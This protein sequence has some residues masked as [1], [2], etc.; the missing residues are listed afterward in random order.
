MSQQNFVP[1]LPDNAP[2]T[3][4]QRAYLNGFL[5]GLFSRAPQPNLGAVAPESKPLTPLTILFGSQ[6]GNAEN[7]SKRIAK[8]AGKRGFA[9][10]VQ[11]L[12][13]YEIAQ[14]VSEQALLIVTSTYG[15]GEPPDNAKAFWEFLSGE[16]APKLAQTKFSLL[17]L[18]DSNYS[19]F[20]AFG[21]GVDERLEKLGATRVHPR[22]DCDVE[23]EEPFAKWMDGALSALAP[24]AAPA[25]TATVVEAVPAKTAS[26]YSKSHPF[27]APLLANVRL[28]GGGSA[29]DTRHFAFSLEGSGLGYEAGDALG[30]RATNCSELA[31]ELLRALGRSG[32]EPVPDRDGKETPLREALVHH[33]EITRIPSPLLKAVAERSGDAELQKLT[34]PGANGELTKFLWGRE[35]IDLLH[36][37]PA[38]KFAPT[39]FVALLKKLQPRLYSISSSP[40]A[41]PGEVHLCVGVVRYD[42]L[43]R[44]RKGVCS[45]FLA[46]RVPAG[47]AV[48]VFVHHNKN[49]RPPA[50]PDAPMIMVGPGTGIAPFR[51]FLEERKAAGAKGKNWLFFGDQ[52]AA[53]DFLFREEIETMQRESTLHRLDLAFSRDQAEKIYVQTRMTEHA[54]ELYAWLEEGGG[55]YVCGD[56]SRMAKDVDAAL[57]QVIQTAGGKSAEEATAYVAALKKDKRYQRDV[58]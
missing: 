53:T 29:K 13:K 44:S 49:F 2:F 9:P 19:K 45:T 5:A 7:L 20:C 41:H 32:E 35:I 39:E 40:K 48:P 34:A 22:T 28:N 12:G 6:T 55:F 16:A 8:E 50:N 18:G 52:R 27:P 25:P 3:P 10:T 37:H 56:A 54:K 11:D 30:V 24:A 4:E 42:S 38:A 57:H 46:E 23:Y 36:G 43:G 58:Y 15:D 21:K 31:E 1:V 33:Y 47:G 51:A 26:T 14:L 17:A